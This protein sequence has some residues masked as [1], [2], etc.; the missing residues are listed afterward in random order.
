MSGAHTGWGGCVHEWFEA[1][2]ARTPGMA[3]VSGGETT[4]SYGELNR[5]AEEVALRLR[6]RGVGP[7]SR[8]GLCLERSVELAPALL[9]IWKAGGTYVPLSPSYPAERLAYILRDAGVT[10]VLTEARL[11]HLLPEHDAEVVLVDGPLPPCELPGRRAAGVS[12]GHLA[13]VI[14][15]SG[16][17]GTPKGVMVEHGSLAATI[18]AARDEFG[19]SGADV[20]ACLASPSFDIFLFELLLPLVSGG[21]SRIVPRERVLDRRALVAELERVTMFH[22]VPSLMRQVLAS[23]RTSEVP[24]PPRVRRIFVGGEAVP[25]VLLGEMREALPA[26]EIRVLYGP[27]EGTIVCAGYRVP[28]DGAAPGRMIGTPLGEAVLL[29]RDE[30]GREV[31]DGEEGEIL[32]GGPGVSRGYLGREEM[33]AERFVVVEGRRFY[34]TGDLARRL[35]DG[36][37][38]FRG[39]ADDQVKVRGFRIEPGEVE[40]VAMQAPGVREVA[41]AAREDAAGELQ[42]VA[43]LV[44][45]PGGSLAGVRAHLRER[46]PEH[47]VPAVLVALDALPLTPQGKVDRRALPAPEQDRPDGEYAAPRTP[48]EEALAE[49]FAGVLGVRRVGIHDDFFALGGHSLRGMQVTARVREA[50]RV[51]LPAGALFEAPTVA[52]LAPVVE[53]GGGGGSAADPYALALPRGDT[54]PLSFSQEAVWFLQQLYPR[55]AAYSFHATIRFTGALDVPVLE[56]TLSEIVRRHEIF[57]TTFPVLDAGPVQRIHPPRPASLPVADLSRARKGDRDAAV[58]SLLGAEFRRPYRL[59]CLPL[60]RWMLLRLGPDEHLLVHAEH[61]FLHDG[62][63][64]GRL[65]DELNRI[66]AA[67]VRGEPSPLPEPAVQFADFAVRQREWVRGPE[68]AAQLAYWR[69]RLAGAPVLE[70]PTDR[71]RPPVMSFRGDAR[72]VKLPPRLGSAVRAFAARHGATV[73]MTLLAAFEALLCRYTGQ[74]DF[75]VGSAVANRRWRSL[76]GVMGFV[77]NTVALRTDL[78]ADP[79]FRVLLDRVRRAALAAFGHADVPFEQVVSILHPDRRTSHLPVYQVAFSFH[80]SPYP[81]FRLPGLAV[82]V[83]DGLGNGSAKFDLNV[84]VIPHA[85]QSAGARSDD[86]TLLWEYSTDLFDEDTVLRLIA[87]YE[88][89]LEAALEDPELRVSELPILTAGE[90]GLLATWNDTAAPFPAAT[91]HG[92]FEAQAERTPEAVAVAFEG[93]TL[94]YRELDARADALARLLRFRGVGPE[95]RVGV[96]LERSVEMVVALLGVLKSGAA[97]VPLDPDYP[98]GRLAYVV[99][100]SAVPVILAQERLRERLPETGAEVVYLGGAPGED[101]VADRPFSGIPYPLSSD[102]LAYVIY[103]SGSTGEPKGV[104]NSHRAVVNRLLWGE[105]RFGLTPGEVVLQ[106]TPFGFDVS[107]PEF[108]GPL[109]AG[110]R[111]VLARPG[112]HRDPAYLSETIERERVTTIHFVPSMLQAFLEAGEPERCRSLRRVSCSGEALTPELRDRFL[113]RFP[114]V[115]LHN[116]YGPTEAAVEVTHHDCGRGEPTV[117][118]GRPVANTRIHVLDRALGEA[119]PGVPGE[120]CIG[121]VQVARG[122]LG[123]PGMT[124]ERFVPDPFSSAAG[125]RLYRTGDRARWRAD[126]TVEYLGRLDEQ[127]K[128]RGFRIE[129]GEVEAALLG[130]PSVAE[131]AVVARD[132]GR[133]GRRLVGYVVPVRGAAPGAAELRAHL[134]E[135]LPEYMVPASFVMLEALPLGPSGKLDRRALPA[136]EED[137][138]GRR[139]ER[140]APRT[141]REAVLVRLWTELLRTEPVGV[142]DNFFELGGDSILAIQ[143]VARAAGA[144]LRL[145]PEQVFRHQTVAGLVAAAD[146]AEP[147]QAERRAVGGEV[148]LTP[149]QRWFFEQEL[150]VPGHWNQ[151][152]LLNVREPLGFVAL[153]GAVEQLQ[154]YHD[155]L[156]LRFER[157]G[158]GWRQA[159]ADDAGP[160]PVAWV[161]L[162]AIGEDRLGACITGVAGQAQASLDLSA[163]PLYRVVYL[164]P[165]RGGGRL[166]FAAHHL[167]V[168]GVSWRILL[169]DLGSALRQPDGGPVRLPPKTVSYQVW[170]ERL[171]E[172]ALSSTLRAEAGFWLAQSGTPRGSLPRDRTDGDNTEGSVRTVTVSLSEEETRALVQEV[173]AAYRTRIDE[174]ILAAVAQALAAWTGERAVVMELEGHGR[175]PLFGGVDLS[176]T[177]GWFTAIYPVRLEVDPGAGP[178]ELLKTVK[179]QL[180]AIPG[181]GVGYG[182]L[183]YLGDAEVAERLAA[184]QPE[185]SF[186]Y[187]GQLD[188]LLPEGSP[189]GLASESPGPTRHPG[190]RRRYLLDVVG[191]VVEG[192]LRMRWHYSEAVHSRETI[193]RVAAEYLDTLRGLVAYCR[194]AGAGG[195]TPSDFPL[196]G[197]SQAALDGVVRELTTGSS[198]RELEDLYPLSPLQQGMLF[199][200]RLDPGAY[201]EQ[202]VYPLR[203]AL[204][205][206]LLRHAWQRVVDRHTALR[207][208]FVWDDLPEPLQGVL[209]RAPVP[210]HEE[211]WRAHPGGERTARLEEYLST[212]RARGFDPGRAPLMRLA[213]LRTGDRAWEMVWSHHHLLLDG[214]SAV[215]VVGEVLAVYGALREG[216]G[217]DL[218][219]PHPYRE[220]VAWLRGQDRGEA[221]AFWRRELEGFTTPAPLGGEGGGAGGP[222]HGETRLVLAEELSERLAALGRRQR[223]TLN[224]LVQGAWALLLAR[225]SGEDDVLFGATV[226]G[227]P[228]EL[229]EVERRIGL[230][231]NT[232][233]VRVRVP[234]AEP[235]LPWLES[236]QERQVAM[237]CFEHTPLVEIP[238]WSGVAP[239]VPLFE[240]LVVFENYPV[241]RPATEE[242]G[243]VTLGRPRTVERASYPLTLV[244][245]PSP[246]LS[247]GLL[248]RRERFDDAGAQRVLDDLRALLEGITTDPGRTLGEIAGRVTAHP[249]AAVPRGRR[250]SPR[251]ATA[252]E[253]LRIW[254]E[255]LGRAVTGEVEDFF[256]LGGDSLAAARTVA[257]IRAAFGVDLPVRALFEAPTVAGLVARVEEARAAVERVS[258]APRT[259]PLG[260][261][262][263]LW[264]VQEHAWRRE[265]TE[266]VRPLAAVLRLAGAL[267][268]EAMRRSLGELVRRH[269]ALRTIFPEVDGRP[270]QVVLDPTPFELPVEEAHSGAVGAGALPER[271]RDSVRAPFDVER[272]PPFRAS[273]FRSGEEEHVLLLAIHPLVADRASLEIVLREL[274]AL[275]AALSQGRPSPLAEP[276]GQLADFVVAGSAPPV[277]PS[278]CCRGASGVHAF[279]LSREVEERVR[280]L[281]RRERATPAMVLLAAFRLL[282][283]RDVA[284]AGMR[285][286]LERAE[287]VVGPFGATVPLRVD[288]PDDPTFRELLRRIRDASLAALDRPRRARVEEEPASRVVFL[289]DHVAPG[290]AEVL[291]ERLVRRAWGGGAAEHDLS[292]R[293]TP[294]REGFAC[295]LEY[296]VDRI[297]PGTVRELTADYRRLVQA[298]AADPRA[299]GSLLRCNGPMPVVVARK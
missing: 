266:R 54:A 35:P 261:A 275:Y 69:E 55:M 41:V 32:L 169:H 180:R 157:D 110:A 82:E 15:T 285:R 19:I 123:K 158:S 284:V 252:T 166:L 267:D 145:T 238:G 44:P 33:N 17:T 137:P 130:H 38:E 235:V 3:A 172:H 256:A 135:R 258:A 260:A 198:G 276:P 58:R 92:L 214:W 56:R 299:R 272:T 211:D 9:G 209:R 221:E 174:V 294:G 264:P 141:G 100:D 52:R 283:G 148:P 80:D 196:A 140:V 128:I 76:E 34:R 270:T 61:H 85:E 133:G 290:T 171:R 217:E 26:A 119:P 181:R 194:S 163:G 64:F 230:F 162:S 189:F 251:S 88:T 39:R 292:L 243:G 191:G 11:T 215:R 222:E 144:G 216:R 98:A 188:S 45:E 271:L 234:P 161:D 117:P 206:T 175:E 70:L 125:M 160:P 147:E 43:Y 183:R 286:H 7:E 116:L 250:P 207:T 185:V 47:M 77:V 84:I 129:P 273:L 63:S 244:V 115:E 28:P 36:T 231:I 101:S 106:K 190:A 57:R 155:A 213:L 205:V 97:Y 293:I 263:P 60:V 197:I 112:G 200:V 150:P 122:Y 298:A 156:R 277:A 108:F 86:L 139:G 118:I 219:R 242:V 146:A 295:E 27:T 153:A 109:L 81:E 173:P 182:I 167:V 12:P 280:V 210:F 13:Y 49:I 142:H 262:L 177:V 168:D 29:L 48:V 18:G 50:L 159:Y 233:P 218:P 23:L 66:Y 136:P 297:D 73:Y 127:V 79:A 2:A 201:L 223:L 138:A 170:S 176:R 105:E 278:R 149:V 279:T 253:L 220:Y 59:D 281:A 287:G 288:L 40:A 24:V 274:R 257:R 193:G 67:F 248:Y 22:A 143:M 93:E 25:P 6:A 111:M 131:A 51:D 83:V 42:L 89:L 232:L 132:D 90:R 241:E 227:R 126:G 72:R 178:G 195:C 53:Q 1:Q 65:L 289:Y 152:F 71:P 113:E 208:A 212:D 91:I 120:L 187:H 225:R 102:H 236:V 20:M 291:G 204:D 68:A 254:S 46:L 246:E 268:V 94:T 282:L 154:R 37:L 224:T 151:A 229:P 99:R 192:R 5:W 164:D 199:H 249:A 75:C 228:A 107:V 21:T 226:S 124:A 114:G 239:G 16:S 78:A 8:V 74:E 104:M 179:E 259:A 184:L 237:R 4:V 186:N 103:T 31:A 165:G 134:G 96:C 296:A 245:R 62:W 255:V 269:G 14:H 247:L 87:H 95:V 240:S 10:V 203:G 121:G 30:A 202:F 265:R